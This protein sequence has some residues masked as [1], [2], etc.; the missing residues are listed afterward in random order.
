MKSNFMNFAF[1][2]WQTTKQRD[3]MGEKDAIRKVYDDLIDCLRYYFQGRW[4]YWRLKSLMRQQ[5][6]R[7]QYG[8]L[9]EMENKFTIHMPGLRTGYGGH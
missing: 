7:D 9:R 5:E 3:I 2:D 4:D 6:K 8:E 1:D